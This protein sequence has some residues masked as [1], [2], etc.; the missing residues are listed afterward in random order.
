MTLEDMDTVAPGVVRI[1]LRTP[2]LPPAT[3]TN[4]YLVGER[5]FVIIE[6]A[7]AWPAE[8]R[9]LANAVR[10]R[11]REG[12]KILGAVVTH[13]HVDHVGGVR[14]LQADFG[15]EVR[16]HPLTH[17]KLAP[18]TVGSAMDEGDPVLAGLGVEVLWTP[19]H[20]PG[21][22]CFWSR[23]KG[24]L[25]GGD[26][27]ATV[28][29]IVIDPDDGGDMTA[30]LTQLARLSRLRPKRIL[31]AHGDPVDSAV[32]HLEGYIRHRL[33][34]EARVRDALEGGVSLGLPVIVARAY[35]DT[36]AVL[37]PLAARSARA[38]LD[39]LVSLGEVEAVR[40]GWRSARS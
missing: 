22:L 28:G 17:A 36:P 16:A 4:A 39:R 25:I 34:R 8:A 9:T 7:A 35:A 30:Y 1:A 19:G 15:V 38:H 23:E 32:E 12:H 37:W 6:P 11:Q 24:W 29:T 26:M 3:H 10:S 40:G 33:Q 2:T 20:A 13:H 14:A 5:D 18:G 21:H 27:V 31:P